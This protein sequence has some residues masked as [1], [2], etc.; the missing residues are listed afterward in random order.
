MRVKI[1][2]VLS[3]HTENMISVMVISELLTSAV[4]FQQEVL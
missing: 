3:V 1:Y 4:T 2:Q